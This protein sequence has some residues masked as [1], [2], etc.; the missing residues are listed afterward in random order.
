[1]DSLLEIERLLQNAY[2]SHADYE[3][4]LGEGYRA[5]FTAGGSANE[6]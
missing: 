5:E 4:Y 3:I 6:R 2:G 1:M